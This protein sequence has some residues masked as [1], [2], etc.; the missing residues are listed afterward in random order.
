MGDGAHGLAVIFNLHNPAGLDIIWTASTL[1]DVGGVT[2][3]AEGRTDFKMRARK[4][5]GSSLGDILVQ[6]Y[7]IDSRT[8][9]H[10]RR[11]KPSKT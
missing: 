3:C 11:L 1:I 7:S 5:Q 6:R 2:S 4:L 10:Q 9:V 8:C